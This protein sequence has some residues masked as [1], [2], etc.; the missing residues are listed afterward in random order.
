MKSIGTNIFSYFEIKMKM[1]SIQIPSTKSLG[2]L[3]MRTEHIK[4]WIRH[5]DDGMEMGQFMLFLV[6]VMRNGG[7][8]A[9][10]VL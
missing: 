6:Q 3:Q 4:A 8:V 5:I 9:H 2:V 10:F 7:K 1:T